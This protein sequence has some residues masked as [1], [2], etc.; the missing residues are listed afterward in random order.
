MLVEGALAEQ[1]PDGFPGRARAGAARRA[2]PAGARGHR[3]LAAAPG[4]DAANSPMANRWS[5]RMAS[6]W[7]ATGCAWRVDATRMRVCW[8]ARAA[9]ARCARSARR[10]EA[11]VQAIEQRAAGRARSHRGGR[12]RARRAAGSASRVRTGNIP[13]RAARSR[14]R[15]RAAS[16][17]RCGPERIDREAAEVQVERERTQQAL[18][19][20]RAALDEATGTAR[21]ARS[22]AQRYGRRT[23]RATRQRTAAREAAHAGARACA[24]AA[25]PARGPA[26]HR[27]FAGRDAAAH[28]RSSATQLLTRQQQLETELGDGDEP[29]ERQAQALNELLSRRVDVEDELAAARRDLEGIEAELRDLDEKRLLTERRVAT[30][31]RGTGVRAPGGAGNPPA[32]RIAGRAVRADAL[33]SGGSPGRAGRRSHH[34]WNA[35]I[36]W[37]CVQADLCSA[38][39]R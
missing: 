19:R 18:E 38:S 37:P 21:A 36:S 24:R 11:A 1:P 29:L 6:G 2:A 22:P 31:A 4:S 15:A 25:D 28:C 23:R 32:P 13:R 16:R 35:R 34:R 7:G 10:C 12:G 27:K 26:F 17:P 14:P 5:R 20:A 3:G 8:S 33:R 39:A 9:S 30:R